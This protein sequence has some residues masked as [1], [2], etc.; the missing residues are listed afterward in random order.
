MRGNRTILLGFVFIGALISCQ[1]CST[2]MT[3]S[4]IQATNQNQQDEVDRLLAS[5]E[6]PNQETKDGVTPLHIASGRGYDKIAKSLIQNKADVNATI[7][8]TFKY[9]GKD[10]PKGATPLMGAIANYHFDIAD[11]LISNGAN[12]NLLTENGSSALMI[13]A[14]KKNPEMVKTLIKKGAKVNETTLYPFEYKGET[15]YS[16]STALMAAIATNRN[17]N[18]RILIENGADVT[19]QTKN[20]VDALIIAA[21]NGDEEIVRLLIEKGAT[22]DT[23]TTQDFTVK[24]QPVFI[25]STALMAAADGGHAGA[26]KLLIQAGADVNDSNERGRPL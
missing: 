16:G 4:L 13:A 1:A 24:G 11:M 12:V 6:N 8:Q 21:A 5:G 7:K 18:A 2:L 22:P 9:K 17:E 23:K 26:V 14:D 20:G 19:K 25:G 10:V 3:P 15:I